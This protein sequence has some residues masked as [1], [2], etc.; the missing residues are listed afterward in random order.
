MG[1]ISARHVFVS[2]SALVGACSAGNVGSPPPAPVDWHAFDAR[3]TPDAGVIGPTARER[4]TAES[5]IAA[6]GSETSGDLGARLDPQAH[7]T[8]PGMKD[9][10][11]RD[12]VVRAHE[13]LLGAFDARTV[14]A[15]RLW[16]TASAQAVEWTM[17]GLQKRDWM[18]VNA[19][20]KPVA[21]RGLTLLWTKDDGA[22]T[23]LHVYFD[24]AVIQ[25]QLGAGSDGGSHAVHPTDA[26]P[27]RAQHPEDL[28][29]L[30]APP[31]AAGPPQVFEQE[32]S[33]EE[34]INVA[35][36]RSALDALQ[37]T[38]EASYV[39]S[40]ADDVEVYSLERALPI[41]GRDELRS[42]FRAMH[43]AIGQLDT[44]V[45]NAWGVGA[46]VVVEY[47]ISGEQ[48]GPIGSVAAPRDR[49]VR[50]HVVDAI[51]MRAGKIA[52]VWRYDN[53]GEARE[54]SIGGRP[55]LDGLLR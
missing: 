53:P 3:H 35:T 41:H 12:D 38:D 43:K 19:T 32:G 24:V 21:F 40:M 20:S 49:V 47:S 9:A 52:R 26:L 6:L 55:E 28:A 39:A 5:Y 30:P 27:D 34:Q 8:F 54:R 7:F 44:I 23:D 16:R 31:P 45:D 42:Y 36:V 15:T 17:G 13:T 29:R 50:F 1:M 2:A 11:G 14:G 46:F 48:L 4:A 25:A 10:R 37:G 33:S 18:G 51:E 22:I